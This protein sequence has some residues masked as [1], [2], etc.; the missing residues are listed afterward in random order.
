LRPLRSITAHARHAN[1]ATLGERIDL[2]G[3]RTSSKSWPTPSTPCSRGWRRP[4]PRNG[5]SPPRPPRAED[6]ARH[7]PRRSDVAL[8]N[9][10]RRIANAGSRAPSVTRSIAVR[11]LVDG[12]LALARSESTLRDDT[13][14]DFAE[15]VG[16]VVGEQAHAASLA[17]VRRS[18]W[19]WASRQ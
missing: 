7:H 14:V 1:E 19:T 16:D 11:R 8:A 2:R 9:E 6:A 3:P 10:T 5:D 17:G 13:L 12:L 4:S 18:I 15:L